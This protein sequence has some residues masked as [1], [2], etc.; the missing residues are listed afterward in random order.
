MH[1]KLV[2]ILLNKERVWEKVGKWEAKKL[3]MKYH[4]WPRYYLFSES[5]E[6][7]DHLSI[8]T[9]EEAPFV[10]V[11]DVDSLSGTCMRNTV[12]CRKQVKAINETEGGIYIKRCCKGFCIDILKKI[13]KYV[14]FTYDL[15]LVTNGKHGKKINGTWNGLV[16]EVVR[17]KA[18][19]AVGSLTINEE[20]SEVVDFSV[21]FIE[22]GISVMVSRSNGTVSPSAFLGNC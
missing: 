5:E 4:V 21:P 6:E 17:K 9:L 2:I 18:Q 14:K 7:D 22:T 13:A 1:P 11:E 10:I 12:P 19:M 8:V 15:Y 16:G 20:R 3:T